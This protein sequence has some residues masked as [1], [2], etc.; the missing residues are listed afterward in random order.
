MRTK[1]NSARATH[2][3]ALAHKHLTHHTGPHVHLHLPSSVTLVSW[4]ASL[5]D[6]VEAVTCSNQD[7]WQRKHP[8]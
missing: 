1:S 6:H 4:K 2:N 7:G 5:E 8:K 3:T